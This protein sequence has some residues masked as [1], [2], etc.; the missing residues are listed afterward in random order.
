ML[1]RDD[2][3]SNIGEL[4]REFLRRETGAMAQKCKNPDCGKQ[5]MGN[6]VPGGK[7]LE[8]ISCPHCGKEH[9][10]EMTSLVPLVTPIYDHG[11]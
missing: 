3:G 2:L 1:C 8:I 10:R 4:G 11:D 7:E 5:L 6:N 9:D